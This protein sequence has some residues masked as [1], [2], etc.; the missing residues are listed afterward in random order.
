MVPISGETNG[1]SGP[2]MRLGYLEKCLAVIRAGLRIGN[3]II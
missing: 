3:G 1:F 2:S